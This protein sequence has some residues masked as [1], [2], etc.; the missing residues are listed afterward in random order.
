MI[1]QLKLRRLCAWIIGMVLVWSSIS[2][3]MDPV[4]TSYIMKEYFHF[5]HLS[6]LDGAAKILGV[7]FS[8]FESTLGI[9]LITGVVR[10]ITAWATSILLGF[11]LILTFALLLVNPQMDCG[12]FGESSHWSHFDTFFKNIILTVLAAGAWAGI[13][14]FGAPKLKKYFTAIVSLS[15]VVVFTVL[16]WI[17]IPLR[18]YTDYAAGNKILSADPYATVHKTQTLTAFYYE[19][20]GERRELDRPF[21]PDSSWHFAGLKIKAKHWEEPAADLLLTDGDGIPVDGLLDNGPV[22]VISLYDKPGKKK[23]ERIRQ[24]AENAQANGFQCV[25]ASNERYNNDYPVYLA[26]KKTLSTFNRSNGGITYLFD[27]EIIAKWSYLLRPGEK[28]LQELAEKDYIEIFNEVNGA[29]ERRMEAF[30]LILF[31]V[32]LLI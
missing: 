29:N 17:G 4:G 25:I 3:L 11:F 22:M 20:D 28:K 2:K 18:D 13:K 27:G 23:W 14:D 7:L 10:R 21:R 26:D 16:S 31:A 9:L 12:C 24:W 8:L 1:F 5:L 19:K 6:F 30:L 32:L 15:L